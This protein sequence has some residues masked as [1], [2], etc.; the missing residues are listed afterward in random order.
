M[1]SCK[2]TRFLRKQ[3]LTMLYDVQIPCRAQ[4]QHQSRIIKAIIRQVQLLRKSHLSFYTFNFQFGSCSIGNLPDL[5][6]FSIITLF[7]Y[8]GK[9]YTVQITDIRYKISIYTIFFEAT[10]NM[11]HIFVHF[12]ISD[13]SKILDHANDANNA[14][15]VLF[16]SS[17][18]R[19]SSLCVF[20]IKCSFIFSRNHYTEQKVMA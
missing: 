3:K 20:P 13:S 1:L 14:I 11:A 17:C 19:S 5:T 7:T 15:F 9:I 4:Q 10:R 6:I 16:A 18:R 12:L 8:T 2:N